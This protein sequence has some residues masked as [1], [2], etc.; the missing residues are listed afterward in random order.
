MCVAFSNGTDGVALLRWGIDHQRHTSF[1]LQNNS[2]VMYLTSAHS[3]WLDELF[4]KSLPCFHA[5]LHL[6]LLQAHIHDHPRHRVRHWTGLQ[7]HSHLQAISIKQP[8]ATPYRAGSV[9]TKRDQLGRATV[10]DSATL[11]YTYAFSVPA[12]GMWSPTHR[13]QKYTLWTRT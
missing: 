5:L 11:H 9:A 8:F 2:S 13:V 7:V 3:A 4:Y 10:K 12:D 1:D 6:H